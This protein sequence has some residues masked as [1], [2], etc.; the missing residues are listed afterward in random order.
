MSF[1]S[2]LTCCEVPVRVGDIE[3]RAKFSRPICQSDTTAALCPHNHA[4]YEMLL[5]CSGYANVFFSEIGDLSLKENDILLIPPFKYH[6]SHTV[7]DNHFSFYTLRFS[8][9]ENEKNNTNQNPLT[10]RFISYLNEPQIVH[11]DTGWIKQLFKQIE[12]KLNTN[13]R[14]YINTIRSLVT[15]VV[16][17]SICIINPDIDRLYTNDIN[18]YNVQRELDIEKFFSDRFSHHVSIKDLSEQLHLCV[19]Q[20]NRMLMQLYGCS[21]SKKL[22]DTRIENAKIYLLSTQYSIEE[23]CIKCGFISLGYFHESFRKRTGIS[24]QKYR[25]KSWI[26]N[27]SL[28]TVK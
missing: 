14:G 11:D 8:I 17:E 27:T 5:F 4:D 9:Y 12:L 18:F 28:R 1:S 2:E 3:L 26:T 19:R 23:I 20:T 25:K 15:M 6:T 21:F 13:K 10:N 24:P 16:V 7:K 22:I